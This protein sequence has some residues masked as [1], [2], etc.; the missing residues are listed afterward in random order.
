MII[1]RNY[2]GAWV[3]SDIIGGYRVARSYY[4]YTKREAIRLFRANEYAGV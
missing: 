4:G 2:Q 1:E 3:I